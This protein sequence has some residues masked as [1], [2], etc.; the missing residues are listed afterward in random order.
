MM[1]VHGINIFPEKIEEVLKTFNGLGPGYSLSATTKMGMNDQ[2]T[3][4]ME[5]SSEIL[6][7]SE[8]KKVVVK[9]RLQ[10]AFRRALGIGVDVEFIKDGKS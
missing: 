4:R 6:E 2:L 9:E 3:V 5:A 10:L 1:C 8:E 7:A